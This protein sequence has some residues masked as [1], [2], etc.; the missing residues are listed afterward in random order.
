MTCFR[1][2]ILGDI[3]VIWRSSAIWFDRRV[4]VLIPIL[5]WGLMIGIVFL[6]CLRHNLYLGHRLITLFLSQNSEHDRPRLVLPIRVL[7]YKLQSIMQR[8][9]YR[10]ARIVHPRERISDGTHALESL[11]SALLLEVF[12]TS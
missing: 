2:M 7:S 12:F 6:F 1:Q 9:R 10:S 5:W 8:H 11:V 3:L 4:V